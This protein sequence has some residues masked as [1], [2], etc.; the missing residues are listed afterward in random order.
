MIFS[1][2]TFL[3]VY[4]I[5][6]T[7]R[8]SNLIDKVTKVLIYSTFIEFGYNSSAIQTSIRDIS[9]SELFQIFGFFYLTFIIAR[10]KVCV[11][12][13]Y[14]IAYI[15]FILA[16]VFS[17]LILVLDPTKLALPKP[18]DSLD[19]LASNTLDLTVSGISN[20]HYLRILRLFLLYP[21]FHVISSN[22]F[23]IKLILSLSRRYTSILIVILIF[24][25]LLKLSGSSVIYEAT[26]GFLV[27]QDISENLLQFRGGL[28]TL[29]GLTQEP[30][31]LAYAFIFPALILS[32]KSSG[33]LYTI[34]SIFL[35]LS[36]SF[37]SFLVGIF[38][39]IKNF[40]LSQLLILFCSVLL[41]LSLTDLNYFSLIIDRFHGLIDRDFDESSTS[42]RM[43]SWG[44]ALDAFDAHPFFG[45]GLG[46]ISSSS[47]LLGSAASV[48][49]IGMIAYFNLVVNVY[50]IKTLN[51][52]LAFLLIFLIFSF[53]VN[54]LYSFPIINLFLYSKI[55]D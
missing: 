7:V 29:H 53:N 50:E 14:L 34:G 24:E 16:V 32:N 10:L 28:P 26:Y 51:L 2:L 25:I 44:Y 4:L 45:V 23:N 13:P 37:R 39:A 17:D 54:V 38:I 1:A 49:I 52:N 6:D 9:Q 11:K 48:G 33:I 47:G 18:G 36:G 22:L 31:H 8:T 15:I 30:S 43:V 19:Q 21:F 20:D 41:I 27:N 5:Y 3:T 12:K 42:I 35:L 55:N 40:K 46:S